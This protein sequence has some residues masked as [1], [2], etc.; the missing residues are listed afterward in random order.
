[1]LNN[2][3]N[4]HSE[5]IKNFFW[6]ALQISGKQGI[7]FII[8]ILCA[9]LLSIEDFGSLNY[10]LAIIYLLVIFSDFGISTSA[11]KYIAE[12]DVKN[13]NNKAFSLS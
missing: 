7:T 1:M 3:F 8:F 4:V 10:L 5:I 11:S 9:K 6:R 12:Y 13:Y 2:L